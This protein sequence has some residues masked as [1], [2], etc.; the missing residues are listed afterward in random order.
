MIQL[1]HEDFMILRTTGNLRIEQRFKKTPKVVSIDHRDMLKFYPNKYNNK[2]VEIDGKKFQSKKEGNRYSE[3]RLLEKAGLIEDLQCQVK[4]EL[5]A[6][7]QHEPKGVKVCDYF[8]DF[9]Y[10]CQKRG[11]W[12][13]E[14]VKGLKNGPA[15]SLFKLKKKWMK[16]QYGITVDEI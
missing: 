15:Y 5:H 3:L 2:W 4:Y 13:Y 10:F 6:H 7:S 11:C 1:S 14:D 12:I 9:E 16:A 8:L